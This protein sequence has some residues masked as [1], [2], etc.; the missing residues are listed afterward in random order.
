MKSTGYASCV[1]RFSLWCQQTKVAPRF[2]D[3]NLSCP[4]PKK[5][6]NE[7]GQET[8]SAHPEFK[9]K[10]GLEALRG[11]KTINEIGQEYG[12]HPVQ[13]GQWKKKIQE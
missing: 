8:Q 11:V 7:R 6:Q 9:A 3:S 1:T 12:V 4:K 5:V 13:V 2:R 10:L